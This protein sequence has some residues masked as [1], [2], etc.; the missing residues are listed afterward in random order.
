MMMKWLPVFFAAMAAAGQPLSLTIPAEFA[1]PA[2]TGRT[3]L[4]VGPDGNEARYRVREQLARISFRSDAVGSTRR[5]QGQ[6]VFDGAGRVMTELSRFVVDLASL[7]TD[8]DRRD[9]YVRRNT[10]VTDSFPTL[11]L[12]PRQLV[13]LQFPLP[14]AGEHEFRMVT[15]MTLRGVTRPVAWDVTAIFTPHGVSGLATTRF[16]FATFAIPIPRVASVLSVEDDIRL[17][18]QF[19]LVLSTGAAASR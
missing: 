12:V 2:D 17:E 9:N 5:V 16:D 11:T 18:Y 19:R 13:G 14:T 10:L 3:L 1:A 8:Q 7:Q 15:D 4:V 6:I